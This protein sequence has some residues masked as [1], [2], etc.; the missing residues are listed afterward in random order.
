MS[1]P[2]SQPSNIKK[3]ASLGRGLGSLLGGSPGLSDDAPPAPASVAQATPIVPTLPTPPVVAPAPPVADE[4]QVWTIPIDRLQPNTQQPR[5]IFTPE[6]LKELSASI[7]EKGI[8]QPIVARRLG[9]REFQ[10]IAGERRWRAAQ[11]AGLHEV[12]VILKKVTEQDSLEYAIIEN[13]QRENLNALE[14]AEAY[15]LLADRYSLTQQQVADKLGKDRSTVANCLRLLGLPAELKAMI[16][17]NELSPGHA[18]VLLGVESPATQIAIAKQVVAEKLSVRATE[19]LAAKS[20]SESRKPNVPQP[21]SLD[22]N[23]TQRLLDS[24]TSELQ[25]LIGTK[26]SIDYADAKGKLQVHFYSDDQLTQIMEKMRAA[27]EK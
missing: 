18:K 4:S 15:E 13:I 2:T 16:R 7:K 19:K 5:Q 21:A 27:W 14:E 12:P 22:V 11:L 24:L 17:K 3:K 6:A 25:K 26:V 9:E 10:I 23:V 1:E 8:L 20:K